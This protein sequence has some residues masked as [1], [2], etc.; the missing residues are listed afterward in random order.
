MKTHYLG[1]ALPAQHQCE[2]DV[3]AES[4]DDLV[5]GDLRAIEQP[6]LA[7]LHSLFLMEHN[8]MA[9]DLKQNVPDLTDEEVYQVARTMHSWC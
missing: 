9:E 3:D 4:S 1:P 6:G 2:L 7:S 8:R 5:A